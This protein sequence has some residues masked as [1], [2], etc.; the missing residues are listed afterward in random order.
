[1]TDRRDLHGAAAPRGFH[2]PG[3][4]RV[5]VSFVVNFEEGAEL[6]V[7]DGD[8]RNEPVYEAVD[9]VGALPDPCM[10]S[11]FGYG[12]R[13][14]WRRIADLL[15]AYGVRATVSACGRAVER[16]AWLV[17]DAIAR[18]HEVSCHGWRWER[19]AGMD[20]ATERAVIARTHAT[21]A[22]ACGV[23][24]VSWHTRSASTPN[25]RRLLV[26]HG[27]F[28]YDSERF[29]RLRRRHAL[30]ARCRGPPASRH[31]VRVRHQRHALPARRRVRP[32]RGFRA[33]LHCRLRLAR[34]RGCRHA[35]HDVGRTAPPH[36]RPPGRIAGL[37][38]LL[39]SLAERGSAFVATRADIARHWLAATADE[40]SR[41]RC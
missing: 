26:E 7:A 16:S 38:M 40:P 17:Q 13:A 10:K 37:D 19:H 2:W 9:D 6:S 11:H 21:I 12:T 23:A 25:T 35:A 34:P 39:A 27:G 18:G 33:L 30:F 41:D 29:G 32:W 24:P 8:E 28:L 31:P 3:A 22:A 5:A 20:E 1:M 15:A 14:G 36:H 4:A